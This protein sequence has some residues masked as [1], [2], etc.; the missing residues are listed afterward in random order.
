MLYLV[1]ASCSVFKSNYKLVDQSFKE[2]GMSSSTRQ[3]AVQ[4]LKCAEKKLITPRH[5]FMVVDFQLPTT[6]KRLWLI[7][8]SSGEVVAHEWVAHGKNSGPAHQATSFSNVVRSN[9]SSLGVYRGLV[10]SPSEHPP[11]NLR[12]QGLE[13]DFNSNALRRTVVLHSSKYVGPGHTGRSYGCFSVQ[14]SAIENLADNLRLGG[15]IFAYYPDSEY[16]EHSEYL[17]CDWI[18]LL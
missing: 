17:N 18:L 12:I 9:K 2:A 11:Y 15:L 16:L 8:T 14:R 13:D 1:L 10:R 6:E 3:A 5:Y 4:A 7:D